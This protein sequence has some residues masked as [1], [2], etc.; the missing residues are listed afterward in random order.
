MRVGALRV[1][2]LLRIDRASPRRVDPHDLGPAAARDLAHAF[3]EHAVD[4]DDRGVAGLEQVDEARLHTRG[5]GAAD[6]Q[7]QRVVGAEHRPQPVGDVVEHTEE[8]GVEMPE[9]RPL[10]RFH[11]LG[12]RVRRTRP[13]QQ[14]IGVNHAPRLVTCLVLRTAWLAG[15]GGLELGQTGDAVPAAAEHVQR[16][17]DAG[18]VAH[19]HAAC[20][21]RSGPGDTRDVGIGQIDLGALPR[22]PAPSSRSAKAATAASCSRRVWR[23]VCSMISMARVPATSSAVDVRTACRSD[24]IERMSSTV[25]P[26]S[27]DPKSSTSTSI[28]SAIQPDK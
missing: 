4:A 2:Q 24:A 21:L 19:H 3:A 28:V 1:E 20:E 15:S 12:I 6:R 10:E 26:V 16:L 27:A 23:S 25:S 14:L 8:L 11:D 17:V 13:E 9:H 18:V 7:R 5:T 22:S